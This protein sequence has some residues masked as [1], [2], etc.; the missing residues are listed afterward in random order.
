MAPEHVPVLLDR[1]L[2]LFEPVF[3][4]AGEDDRVLVDATVGL[5]GHSDALLSAYPG[6]RLIALD[7][8]PSALEKSAER[9]ARHGDRVRFV[10][11]RYDEMPG[12]LAELG[13]S[14]VHGILFDLG[15]SSMQLDRAERG[16]AYSKDAPLDMRMDPTTGITAAE[17]LN[18]YPPGEIVRIL[19][20]YGEERFATRIVKKVVAERA[21]EPFT[22]SGRLVELLYNAVPAASRR[23]GGHPAK[24]TFQAL[25]IEVNGEL[26][27][28]R[29]AMPGALGVL[30]MGG[31]I[32]IESYQS[33]EDRLVKQALAGLIKSRTPEGLPV[34]LPGHGPQLKMLTR[35]AEKAGETE[36]EHNPRAASVRLRAAE[37]IGKAV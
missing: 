1:I 26:D 27:S 11:A 36:T 7:R 14:R 19:R 18:T 31:R 25:R 22:D 32:V 33:L 8:D 29:D 37:R 21:R 34:E 16:F 13:L 5:G 30:G 15:V 20:E 24:R 6:M 28:L 2:E 9:L 12:V 35:G 10:H 23:T 17:V 4:S 3:G